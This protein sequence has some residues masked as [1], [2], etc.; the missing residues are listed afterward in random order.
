MLRQNVF[1]EFLKAKY[2]VSPVKKLSF[3]CLE[4]IDTLVGAHVPNDVSPNG[5]TLLVIGIFCADSAIY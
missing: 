4:F 2:R 3:S 1:S 5:V